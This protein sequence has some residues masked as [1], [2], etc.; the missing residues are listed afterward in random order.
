MRDT[1]SPPPTSGP[2]PKAEAGRQSVHVDGVP[3]VR[4]AY[5]A[6]AAAPGSGGGYKQPLSSA[7]VGEGRLTSLLAVPRTDALQ[8]PLGVSLCRGAVG[9]RFSA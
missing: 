3:G 5:G 9:L 6:P 7:R 4:G 2:G 1:L 8:I